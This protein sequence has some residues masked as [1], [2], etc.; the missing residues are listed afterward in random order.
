MAIVQR[1]ISDLNGQEGTDAEF[2][3]VIVRQHPTLDQPKALDVL[4]SE[5]EQFKGLDDLVVLE[6]QLPNGSKH[7]VAM[8]LSE[9]NKLN[10]N[11]TQV[12]KDARG[13]RGRVP[14]TRIGNNTTGE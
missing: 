2:A 13:T 10:P 5:T 11:M 7:D 9:F 3:L 14:G 12:L 4:V 1:R 6:V 8:R